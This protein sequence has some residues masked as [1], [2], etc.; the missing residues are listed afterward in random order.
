MDQTIDVMQ[1]ARTLIKRHEGYSRFPKPDAH[2]T[3]QIGYGLNLTRR[4]LDQG[5]ADW[6]LIQ[7]VRRLHDWLTSFPFFQAMSVNRKAVLI[8][9]AYNLGEAGIDQFAR[10]LAWLDKGDYDSA[11]DEMLNSEWRQQ[12]GERAVSDAELMRRG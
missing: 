12:V 2:G 11:A 3:V 4:G 7:E 6:L 9:M 8:D 5:E 10:M 1:T